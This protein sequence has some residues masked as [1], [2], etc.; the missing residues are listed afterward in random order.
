MRTYALAFILLAGCVSYSYAQETTEIEAKHEKTHNHYI[1]VQLNS[2][3]RQVI[4]F[5]NN[6][7]TAVV[8]PYQLIYSVNSIKSG[9]GIRAG[10]GYNYNS[11]RVDDGITE[12]ETDINDIRARIGVEKRFQLSKKWSAGAGLDGIFS[13]N[14]DYTKATI[15]SFDTTITI[16]KSKLP[17]KGG[18]VMGWLRY[19][20]SDKILIGTE[21]SF[22]Y[23]TGTE[24][25][26]VIV[27]R[28]TAT[29][30]PPFT[31]EIVTTVTKSKPILSDGSF[32]S[33]V[34]FYIIVKI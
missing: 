3:I 22:Y 1:G 20:I 2:L 25:R 24:N 11:S 32:S 14:D 12:T 31:T 34:V 19:S 28:R 23:I 6:T 16:T 9:W 15:H 21:A 17:S 33:P 5:N 8:N 29:T 26:E 18:G 10:I 27:T 30:V 13:N 7:A 4:N